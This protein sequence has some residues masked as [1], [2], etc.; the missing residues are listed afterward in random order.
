MLHVGIIPTGSLGVNVHG[1]TF[2]LRTPSMPV[3]KRETNDILG[4]LR[5]EFWRMT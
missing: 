5:T 2:L 4:E 3:P 1:V